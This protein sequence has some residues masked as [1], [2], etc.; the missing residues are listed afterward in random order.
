MGET[1]SETNPQAEGKAQSPQ[2]SEERPASSMSAQAPP[3]ESIVENLIDDERFLSAVDRITESRVHRSTAKFGNFLREAGDPLRKVA[4]A[5]KAGKDPDQAIRDVKLDTIIAEWEGGEPEPQ[6]PQQATP[7]GAGPL[8]GRTAQDMARPYLSE[9][10][11][12]VRTQ[13]LAEIGNTAFPDSGQVIRKVTSLLASRL[14]RPTPKPSQAGGGT[15]IVPDEP[16]PDKQEK[17]RENYSEELKRTPP[18]RLPELKRKYRRQGL[19]LD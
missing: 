3:I 18:D 19:V 1:A 11:E 10:P 7:T 14:N 17:L 16:E 4:E 13:I 12:E 9:A 6:Q 8:M 2:P 5:V 15:A